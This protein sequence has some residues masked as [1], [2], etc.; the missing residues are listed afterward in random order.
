[1]GS[2]VAPLIT[3]W[4][5]DVGHAGGG[6]APSELPPTPSSARAAG[7]VAASSAAATAA[8]TGR[9]LDIAT[10]WL[11]QP[12][13]ASPGPEPSAQVLSRAAWAGQPGACRAAR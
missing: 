12:S 8:Q 13:T 10:P 2:P 11:T 6:A 7:S 9:S 4:K 1:M 3:P 5:G